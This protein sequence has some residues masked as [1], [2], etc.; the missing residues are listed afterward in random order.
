MP[1]TSP[2]ISHNLNRAKPLIMPAKIVASAICAP[3]LVKDR[4]W[5]EKIMN[6]NS[7]DIRRYRVSLFIVQAL[8]LMFNRSQIIIITVIILHYRGAVFPMTSHISDPFH[9]R[10]LFDSSYTAPH[11]PS[12]I[13]CSLCT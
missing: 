12:S 4:I 1:L 7:L 6:N 9:F 13:A 2:T 5:V 10:R 8:L 3:K 11:I